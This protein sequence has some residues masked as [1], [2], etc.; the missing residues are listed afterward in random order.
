MPFMRCS[1][2]RC[3]SPN[4]GDRHGVRKCVRKGVTISQVKIVYQQKLVKMK[5]VFTYTYI[6]IYICKY[7]FLCILYAKYIQIYT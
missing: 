2:A 5:K 7:I 4:C 6:Y 3:R 1:A